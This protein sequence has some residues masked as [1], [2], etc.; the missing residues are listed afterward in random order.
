M[1]AVIRDI[2]AVGSVLHACACSYTWIYFKDLLQIMCMIYCMWLH[3]L[4][5]IVWWHCYNATI[6]ILWHYNNST[7]AYCICV[8]LWYI[9]ACT[10][11][12]EGV[13]LYVPRKQLWPKPPLS[14]IF[15]LSVRLW[16]DNDMAMVNVV[17][18]S[19]WVV[20]VDEEVMHAALSLK[21]S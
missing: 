11:E 9:D 16:I 4:S 12:H 10:D 21:C 17:K 5:Y 7:T 18:L 8:C 6:I 13:L 3:I 19:L 15:S 14:M 1:T 20:C 2:L